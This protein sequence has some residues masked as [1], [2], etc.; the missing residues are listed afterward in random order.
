MGMDVRTDPWL[1]RSGTRFMGPHLTVGERS[2]INH[3]CFFENEQERVTIG[4]DCKVG[5]RVLFCTASHEVGPS[6]RRGGVE[7]K[8][9]IKV[10]DGV[11]IGAD[12][13]IL[14]GVTIGR[15]CIVAAGAVVA[16]DC[17]PDGLYAGVPARRIRDLPVQGDH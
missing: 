4:A 14:P 9:P 11:W 7:I 3:D 6:S 17:E 10:E 2:F 5:M 1:I 12:S 16:T 8:A 13:T 15:G